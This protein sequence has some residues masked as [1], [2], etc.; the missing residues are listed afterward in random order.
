MDFD[1]STIIDN[2]TIVIYGK[3][4]TGKSALVEKIL[5]ACNMTYVLFENTYD[6]RKDPYPY[7]DAMVR[8]A[9]YNEDVLDAFIRS[10]VEK[11][12]SS[13]TTVVLDDVL[14]SKHHANSM[15]IRRLFM[16]GRCMKMGCII[17]MQYPIKLCPVITSNTDYVFIF[18][19]CS[20]ELKAVY[21][22]YDIS[23]AFEISFEEFQRMKEN[24]GCLVVDRKHNIIYLD[25]LQP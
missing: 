16:N 23:N 15:P 19:L 2:P 8:Y 22:M 5:K 25:V 11:H 3:R 21:A 7:K 14:F 20:A 6:D 1:I 9:N 18:N 10:H 12:A 24:S 13:N 4:A 17:S